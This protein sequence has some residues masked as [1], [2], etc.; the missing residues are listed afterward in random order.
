MYSLYRAWLLR[1]SSPP[2]VIVCVGSGTGRGSHQFSGHRTVLSSQSGY[3]KSLLS[4]PQTADTAQTQ[5]LVP[6]VSP[7]VF[8][9]LLTF[10]Y[11]GYL[12]LTPDNIY[13]VLLATH[14]LHMPR[15]LDLCRSFLLQQ[16]HAS[17]LPPPPPLVKPIPSRKMLP[18]LLPPPPTAA[19]AAAGV[20]W[21]PPP[22]HPLP[23]LSEDPSRYRSVFPLAL[24]KPETQV[25]TERTARTSPLAV[26]STSDGRPGTP[27]RSSASPSPSQASDSS[28][29][30]TVTVTHRPKSKK[31]QNR[32]TN[33]KV[34]VDI[35]CCD[36]PVRFHRVL[37]RNYGVVLR[38]E[39]PKKNRA[40][41]E[42]ENGSVPT[43]AADDK[44]DE[45]EVESGSV[46]R[47]AG[48]VFTCRFCN[49][50]FKSHYCYQKHARRHINPVDPEIRTPPSATS[51]SPDEHRAQQQQ[52]QRPQQIQNI[53]LQ[54]PQQSPH[55]QQLQQ[56][57]Q[58][59]QQ[60]QQQPQEVRLLDMNVQYYPCKTCGSKFPSYYFVHKHRKLCHPGEDSA[61][62]TS[63]ENNNTTD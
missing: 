55:L 56:P 53:T 27:P 5:I 33:G 10:M 29:Q 41:T 21:P 32:A 25:S 45:P 14:L 11:T 47:D 36:G 34:I 35:A 4:E 13:G 2:D 28:D 58:Q 16:Q 54:E 63:Q 9:P 60:Q 43:G 48:P 62:P 30:V 22:Y 1:E 40:A 42:T 31:Q 24:S 19:A 51:S 52:Q 49:H 61:T 15:A 44:S 7:E 39:A 3:L 23:P 12:D 6:N 26:P 46:S 20:Y 38:K 59:P 57:P 50:T 37:N 18:V 8:A 17:Q